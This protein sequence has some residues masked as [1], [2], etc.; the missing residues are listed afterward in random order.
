ML[1][2]G[3]TAAPR[4]FLGLQAAWQMGNT[5]EDHNILE[6]LSQGICVTVN[7]DDPSYFGGYMT[8]NFVA[9]REKLQMSDE[10]AKNLV[11]NSI[12]ASFCNE[13]RKQELS[14]MLGAW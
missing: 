4:I 5:P 10:Q 3:S 11:Q 9:L 14:E 12:K 13:N 8:E 7:S 6:M 2:Q 1:E